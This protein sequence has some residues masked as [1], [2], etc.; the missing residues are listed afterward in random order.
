[1]GLAAPTRAS[2]ALLGW[3]IIS[4]S[5]L[6]LDDIKISSHLLGRGGGD[7]NIYTKR[8]E[9]LLFFFLKLS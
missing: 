6:K 1:M 3:E 4:G 5:W 2:N 7:I 8:H 9:I